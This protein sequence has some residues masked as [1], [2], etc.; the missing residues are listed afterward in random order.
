MSR[1]RTISRLIKICKTY[2]YIKT[3]PAGSQTFLVAIQQMEFTMSARLSRSKFY[4]RWSERPPRP[5]KPTEARKVLKT[6]RGE[7]R[8]R[9][10]IDSLQAASG[11]SY[12]LRRRPLKLC[13]NDTA[14]RLETP[15]IIRSMFYVRFQLVQTR[16]YYYRNF[17]R[18]PKILWFL[19]T[20]VYYV[21]Y[22]WVWIIKVWT[23]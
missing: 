21:R 4:G 16:L 6:S 1:I 13:S 11:P 22:K 14:W 17:V 7:R 9:S 12:P 19:L 15:F 10:C 3:Q 23:D 18:L 20:Y 8:G 2:E 5:L